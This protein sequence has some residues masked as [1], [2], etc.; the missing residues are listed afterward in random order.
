MTLYSLC[1]TPASTLST[2]LYRTNLL[3]VPSIW[4]AGLANT[5]FLYKI[6]LYKNLTIYP[7]KDK[8]FFG[9][10][11]R[12]NDTLFEPSHIFNFR[13]SDCLFFSLYIHRPCSFNTKKFSPQKWST[14]LP[15]QWTG[16][17]FRRRLFFVVSGGD[18][19]RLRLQKRE[20]KNLG[21][22]LK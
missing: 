17:L 20:D 13:G 7:P 19:Y 21:R 2:S 4:K 1:Y 9:G 6:S 16:H 8:N 11:L 5:Y 15:Y 10:T 22:N 12:F 3:L 18:R 14:G